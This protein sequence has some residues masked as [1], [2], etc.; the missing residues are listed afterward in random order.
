MSIISARLDYRL[1]HGIVATQWAPYYNPM[2]IMIVDTKTANDQLLKD[3][4]RIG[5][6]AGIACSIIS[7]ETALK[8]FKAHKYDGQSIFLVTES[9]SFI[10]ELL[11]A[12]E[13]IGELVLGISR[14]TEV[15]RKISNRYAVLAEDEKIFSEILDRGVPI[16]AQ[17][18]PRDK[19]E[20]FI[21]KKEEK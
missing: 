1:L 3:S 19:K 21:S 6:P 20:V 10:L 15:G 17:Y 4:M 2:R 9:P 18:V 12:K 8:N 5:K 16:Y 11:K 7:E 13:T 14:S